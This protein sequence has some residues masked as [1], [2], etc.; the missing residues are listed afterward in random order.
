M[1]IAVALPPEALSCFKDLNERILSADSIFHLADDGE[2]A[3]LE[4][5]II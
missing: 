3:P 1:M 4:D 5:F 2:D